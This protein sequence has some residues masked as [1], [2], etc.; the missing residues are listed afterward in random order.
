MKSTLIKFQNESLPKDID[1]GEK[2]LRGY[3]EGCEGG[4]RQEEV[5]L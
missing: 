5:D 1:Q 4:V 3:R 2:I